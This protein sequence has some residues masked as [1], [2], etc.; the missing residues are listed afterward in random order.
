[1]LGGTL[2]AD[3]GSVADQNVGGLVD[4]AIYAEFVEAVLM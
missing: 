1:V 4:F 3:E 2:F